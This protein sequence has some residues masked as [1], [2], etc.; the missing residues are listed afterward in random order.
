MYASHWKLTARGTLGNNSGITAE[1]FVFGVN[2]ATFGAAFDSTG[3]AEGIVQPDEDQF[4][5]LVSDTVA[6]FGRA[7]TGISPQARL[8]EVKFAKIGADGKYTTAPRIAAVNVAGA[9]TGDL[10]PPQVAHA[11]SLVT[12]RRGPTGKGRFYL[13]MPVAPLTSDLVID[14]AHRDAVAGSC[15]TWLNDLGN[16]PG[17][18]VLGLAVVVASTKGYNTL[19]TGVRVGKALDTIRTRRNAL[20]ESYSAT[21]AVNAG[22]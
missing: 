15:Q 4:N 17:T 2:L 18:D 20:A 6:F 14:D 9:G 5:D 13:P 22:T 21:L 11:V 8:R 12:E 1:Q 19:V 10:H 3:D 7:A 16:E